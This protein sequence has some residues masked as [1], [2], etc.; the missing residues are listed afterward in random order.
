MSIVTFKSYHSLLSAIC[1]PLN[2]IMYLSYHL[3]ASIVSMIFFKNDTVY[4]QALEM[5]SV[6][7]LIIWE[8]M[9]CQRIVL[10][11]HN[12]EGM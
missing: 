2:E 10:K 5:G 8:N 9:D 3:S 4:F 7:T 1:L 12:A 6:D 11:N